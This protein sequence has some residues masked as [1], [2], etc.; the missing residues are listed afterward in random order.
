[1]EC[2]RIV[3]L[4]SEVVIYWRQISSK[5]KLKIEMSLLDQYTFSQSLSV[6]SSPSLVSLLSCSLCSQ[7]LSTTT[8]LS[9]GRCPHAICQDCIMTHPGGNCPVEGCTIPA[10]P[11]DYKENRTLGQIAK[12]LENIKYLLEKKVSAMVL[13]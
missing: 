9:S 8:T 5:S 12:C 3:V 13:L 7:S 4:I 11:K 2:C 10:H 1:M 6:L